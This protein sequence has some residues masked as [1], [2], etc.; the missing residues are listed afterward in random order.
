MFNLN[1]K[2]CCFL[3]L[4]I[5]VVISVTMCTI[6]LNLSVSMAP[7]RTCN[8]SCRPFPDYCTPY[9][10]QPTRGKQWHQWDCLSKDRLNEGKLNCSLMLKELH[11]IT[12][13]MSQ[14][15]KQFP[16]AFII[17]IH[18]ELETFM[19][20][21][22]AIYF[23]QNIYCIHVDA[24]VEE[25]Y[26][27]SVQQLA[28]CFPNVFLSS[29]SEVV[30]Y[31]GFSRL[32]ADLNCM[33]DLNTSQVPWKRVINLCGQDFPIKSNL[34]LVRHLQS[35]A[36]RDTNMTPGIRQPSYMRYRTQRQYQEV[37][38]L[39]TV[40]RGHG[41]Y[42]T[43]PPHNIE[44]YFGTAYYAL[45]RPF[46]RFVL[47]DRVAKDLL[48]WSRDTYSPDEHYWVT[49]NHLVD[50]PGSN[51][52]GEWEGEIRTVKW[53]DQEGTQHNGCKGRYIRGICIYGLDDLQ[54]IMDGNHMFANKFDSHLFPE[55]LNCIELWHR[56]KVLQHA[57]VPVQPE[58]RIATD[59]NGVTAWQ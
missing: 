49:L 31:A 17:T 45:T 52:Q 14:E 57:Q 33:K 20:L 6:F 37:A 22:R 50:A 19:R 30:T 43:P 3:I 56:H 11:F 40:S 58:W 51:P 42:K 32:Q 46:V 23:P 16:L 25:S 12:E 35:K 8:T 41:I 21:L 9:L 2:V 38:G 53:S 7:A 1:I 18:K 15:E 5:C 26:K 13:P 28:N 24:K 39:H 47:E 55:A 44:I 29:I 27:A 36:W 10:P 54:W 48:D 4:A 34:E 59:D